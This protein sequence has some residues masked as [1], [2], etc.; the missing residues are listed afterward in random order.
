MYILTQAKE[1]DEKKSQKNK[2]RLRSSKLLKTPNS[3]PHLQVQTYDISNSSV[4][5]KKYGTYL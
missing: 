5:K 2:E 4:Q 1:R 3:K